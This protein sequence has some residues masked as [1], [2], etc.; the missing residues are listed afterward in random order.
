VDAMV[1][2]FL[3]AQH[4][5][6]QLRFTTPDPE[7]VVLEGTIGGE[8]MRVRLKRRDMPSLLVSRGF[9]LISEGPFNR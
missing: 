7:H 6:G 1:N 2:A 5:P 4:A 8:K 9:H 3:P